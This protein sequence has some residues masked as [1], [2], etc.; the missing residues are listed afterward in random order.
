MRRLYDSATG[1]MTE[2]GLKQLHGTAME[3]AMAM[4]KQAAAAAAISAVA[5]VEVAKT[6]QA[7][8]KAA[9]KGA[10]PQETEESKCPVCE[11]A[12]KINEGKKRCEPPRRQSIHL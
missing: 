12:A 3:M 6:G 5:A 2:S 10:D 8:A 4:Q 11:C 7:G 1:Q 9:G